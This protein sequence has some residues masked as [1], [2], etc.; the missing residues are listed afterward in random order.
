MSALAARTPLLGYDPGRKPLPWRYRTWRLPSWQA[1]DDAPFYG[2]S[3]TQR[4][5]VD[6]ATATVPRHGPCPPLEPGRTAVAMERGDELFW[7]GIVWRNSWSSDAHHRQLSLKS[8]ESVLQCLA[9]REPE[10]GGA[11][12]AFWSAQNRQWAFNRVDQIQIAR[13]LVQHAKD[14]P[15]CGYLH[16]EIPDELWDGVEWRPGE[17]SGIPRERYYP[18]QARKPIWEALDQMADALFGFE[19]RLRPF[20]GDLPGV[21]FRYEPGYPRLGRS[22]AATGWVMEHQEGFPGSSISHYDWPDDASGI[23]NVADVLGEELVSTAMAPDDWAE[24][25]RL[26]RS[27]V[28]GSVRDQDT[29]DGYAHAYLDAYHAPFGDQV[30]HLAPN[31]RDLPEWGDHARVRL[32]SSDRHPARGAGPGLDE[33]F[34][35]V[36]RVISPPSR[37]E[38]ERVQ[39]SVLQP[40]AELPEELE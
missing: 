7:S 31:Q 35:I 2:V 19:Q 36:E 27:W 34:R 28:H 12:P 16:I 14:R 39:F 4:G 29:L 26:E 21:S 23:A 37:G 22:A 3:I 20:W 9:I 6:D 40:S 5:G 38:P 24:W 15:G 13:A 33:V 1:Q 10:G 18:S 25:P 11:A 30:L 17:L 32:T 8:W